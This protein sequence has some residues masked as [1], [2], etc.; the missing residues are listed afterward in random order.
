[1]H[2]NDWRNSFWTNNWQAVECYTVSN[3]MKPQHPNGFGDDIFPGRAALRSFR[4][5]ERNNEEKLMAGHE[6]LDHETTQDRWLLLKSEMRELNKIGALKTVTGKVG[7]D[8]N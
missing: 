4:Y 1:M 8:G 2:A 7:T 6:V 3:N 5:F